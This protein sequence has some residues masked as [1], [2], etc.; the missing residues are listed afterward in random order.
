[1]SLVEPP[2][3]DFVKRILVPAL[4][5]LLLFFLAVKVCMGSAGCNHNQNT[6]E[7]W[8]DEYKSIPAQTLRV[9]GDEIT[10]AIKDK[11]R[12]QVYI[13]HTNKQKPQEGKW[14][15]FGFC[16][17]CHYLFGFEALK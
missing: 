10:I 3:Y 15:M 17:K 8:E 7:F 12:Q 16:R 6:V 9:N 13:L 1:M 2:G 4:F 5:V 14:Y 11:V